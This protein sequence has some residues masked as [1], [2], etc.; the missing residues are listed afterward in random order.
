MNV[1]EFDTTVELVEY[2]V[3]MG[4][5]VPTEEDDDRW[6]WDTHFTLA[7]ILP[8]IYSTNNLPA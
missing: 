8:Q 5:G 6:F 3:G 2:E 7:D 4:M 1:Q